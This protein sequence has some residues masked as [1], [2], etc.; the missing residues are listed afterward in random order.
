M[1]SHDDVRHVAR[2][3]RLKLG[4]DELDRYAGQLSGI[5]GHI[6]K[7]SELD[8]DVVEPTAQILELTNVFRADEARPSISQAE[9][10]AN[11]AEVDEGAFRVPPII[12]E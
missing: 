3:A 2:L 9:A 11:G 1:V 12:Q 5:L 6:D 7:I 10:L 4:D 8:L